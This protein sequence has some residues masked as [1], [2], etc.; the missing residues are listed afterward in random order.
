MRNL[1]FNQILDSNTTCLAERYQW[2]S[3]Y[4]ID[5]DRLKMDQCSLEKPGIFLKSFTFYLR[6]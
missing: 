2:I 5:R 3:V 4:R 1:P 6:I